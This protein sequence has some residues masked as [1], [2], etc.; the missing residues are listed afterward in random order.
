M[1]DE[2]Q[3]SDLLERW[4]QGQRD[5]RDIPATEL[6]RDVPELLPVV[7]QRIQALRPVFSSQLPAGDTAATLPP[8]SVLDEE[9]MPV[10]VPS[11]PE[12]PGYEIVR[13]IGQ[14]GMG[15]VYLAR[16]V[17]LQRTVA[18]K[19]PRL[20]GP[21][22]ATLRARFLREARAAA[23]LCH[24]NICPIFEL[25]EAE[26]VPYLT[27]PFIRGEPLTSRI[28]SPHPPQAHEAVALVQKV[29]LAVEEAH[30]H[31]IIHRDLKPANI[32]I[33]EQG[34]PVIMDFGLAFQDDAAGPL[35]RAGEVLGTPAYM[36]P[37]QFGCDPSRVSPTADIYSLGVILYELLTGAPPFQ[38]G[39]LTLAGQVGSCDPPVP[40]LR[41][42]GLDPRLDTICLQALARNPADRWPSMRALADALAD[43]LAS[44]PR[45]AGAAATETVPPAASGAAGGLVLRVEGTPYAY[46]PLPG[47]AVITLGRQKRKPGCPD[48]QG[49]DIVLRVPSNQQ[50]SARISRRHLEIHRK[51]NGYLLI[52]RSKVG[53]LRNGQPLN[54]DVPARLENG[55]R[56]VVAGVL[57][58]E[59]LI[60][61]PSMALTVGSEVRVP[62]VNKAAATAV[63]EVSVGDVVT[64]E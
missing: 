16:D 12:V 31:G 45:S 50:L 20:W 32:L 42:P 48:G 15:V 52:D 58:L 36:P 30:R 26:G 29:A 11:L 3:V 35:T 25:G 57:S 13:E 51:G 64:F 46:R 5:G 19:I 6:C 49:N 7:E 2:S 38:G 61:S 24:R 53:T 39:L 40:S 59:V 43:W 21:A 18:L 23:A 33:D 34:E 55:D 8:T 17:Q 1:A 63:L 54:R 28:K 9:S 22:A 14:G 27:M 60:Q 41:R 47:Q 44:P 37:E 62:T 4:Q 10:P 56:L